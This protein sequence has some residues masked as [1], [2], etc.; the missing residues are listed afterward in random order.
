LSDGR[1][2]DFR[3]LGILNWHSQ[4]GIN[5]L[6]RCRARSRTPPLKT[7]DDASR[8]L[9]TF[10]ASGPPAPLFDQPTQYKRAL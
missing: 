6:D 2:F 10:A 7:V 9:Q 3:G 1:A 5:E 4:M 8:E